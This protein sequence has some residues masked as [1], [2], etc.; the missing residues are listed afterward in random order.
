M[1]PTTLL[2]ATHAPLNHFFV[3]RVFLKSFNVFQ[4]N[5]FFKKSDQYYYFKVY[6]FKIP[7]YVIKKYFQIVPLLSKL[8]LS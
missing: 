4:K 7:K 2:G 8:F 6:F 5:F 1:G 3:F